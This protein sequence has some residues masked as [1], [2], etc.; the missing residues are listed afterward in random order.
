MV[1]IAGWKLAFFS[2]AI[3][4]SIKVCF[5]GN[6]CI[7]FSPKSC[8]AKNYS[9]FG[10]DFRCFQS[11]GPFG[12]PATLDQGC[13]SKATTLILSVDAPPWQPV[14][15]WGGRVEL[16]VWVPQ[17]FYGN[18]KLELVWGDVLF[19]HWINHHLDS[20]RIF[21]RW[22]KS[23]LGSLNAI[24]LIFALDKQSYHMNYLVSFLSYTL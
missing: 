10:E 2:L 17:R 6:Y 1:K 13:H 12:I 4:G 15:V 20:F 19:S 18:S 22:R 7:L 8:S 21:S 14:D 11:H 16:V 9:F 3:H 23:K 5:N 24:A